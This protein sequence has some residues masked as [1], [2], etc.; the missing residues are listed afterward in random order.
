MLVSHWRLVCGYFKHLVFFA[1][2]RAS[3]LLC[4]T[5][6]TFKSSEQLTRCHVHFCEE[7][8]RLHIYWSKTRQGH[9]LLHVVPL[10]RSNGPRL[11]SF[12]ACVNLLEVVL[13]ETRI[14]LLWQFLGL[15]QAKTT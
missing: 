10:A 2:L 8:I 3:N 12:K 6:K 7:G 4:K 13:L 15:V 1:M 14:V 9:D 5:A 11:C